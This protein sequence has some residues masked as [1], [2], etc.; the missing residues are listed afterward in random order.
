MD[1]L[2]IDS[3]NS[4]LELIIVNLLHAA[5]CCRRY[6]VQY[7]TDRTTINL[8]KAKAAE[9]KIDTLI[10]QYKKML[11]VSDLA[12]INGHASFTYNELAF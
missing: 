8:K 2:K 7:F 6:Q 12:L 11:C 10:T 1:K 5:D 3:R 4:K 9:I